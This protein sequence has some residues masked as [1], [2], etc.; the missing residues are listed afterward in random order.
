MRALPP[1]IGASFGAIWSL[2]VPI[3]RTTKSADLQRVAAQSARPCLQLRL[4]MRLVSLELRLLR[5]SPSNQAVATRDTRGSL[6]LVLCQPIFP[7]VQPQ[8]RVLLPKERFVEQD[9]PQTRPIIY[10]QSTSTSSFHR[11]TQPG[12]TP[13]STQPVTTSLREAHSSQSAFRPLRSTDRLRLTTQSLA[14]I[15]VSARFARRA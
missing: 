8:M 13:F 15:T 4:T 9:M 11:D 1:E 3:P 14:G 2:M 7:L 10:R 5:R 6:I 12:T